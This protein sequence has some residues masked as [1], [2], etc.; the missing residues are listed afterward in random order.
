MVYWKKRKMLSHDDATHFAST[1]M[2]RPFDVH[3]AR[4]KIMASRDDWTHFSNTREI[5]RRPIYV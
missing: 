5:Y 1:T 4:R 3:I 2:G